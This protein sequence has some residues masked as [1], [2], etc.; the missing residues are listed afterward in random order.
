MRRGLDSSNYTCCDVKALP[1]K[2]NCFDYVISDSTLDHFPSESQIITALEEMSRVLKVGG[3][4]L[5]TI[6]NKSN[7]TYPPYL[8]MQLWMR[9][10]LAPYFIGKTLSLD[11]S[12]SIIESLGL[13]LEDSTAIFHC[14]HPDGLIRGL[15]S[16]TH[17][18]FGDKLNSIMKGIFSE[19]ESLEN[20]KIKLITG[21]YLA[22]KAIKRK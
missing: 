20:T 18:I 10:G 11:Q 16:I 7:L 6:D 3:A 4:L 5:L 9:L 13:A 19:L 15:E 2:D 1:F 21:R 8:F 12:K 14:P 22:L 17:I